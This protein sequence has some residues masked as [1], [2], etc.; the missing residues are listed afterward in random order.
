[1]Q[2]FLLARWLEKHF[3]KKQI[4]E[5]YLN[6]VFFGSGAYGLNTAAKR[7]FNKD[8]AKLNLHEAAILAGA[9]A[10]IIIYV[11]KNRL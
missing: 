5:I 2:E 1:M 10:A 7:F 3:T 6:R 4:L 11:T 8:A 9:L